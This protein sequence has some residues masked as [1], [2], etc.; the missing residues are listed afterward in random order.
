MGGCG[1][2]FPLIKSNFN[3]CQRHIQIP[4]SQS[5]NLRQMILLSFHA[6]LGVGT[7]Q[8]LI[9]KEPVNYFPP[10]SKSQKKKKKGFVFM[11][12]VS[13]LLSVAAGFYCACASLSG[14]WGSTAVHSRAT[15]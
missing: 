6:T 1:V 7:V 4:A 12:A 8:I 11:C 14:F 5:A 10:A 13:V 9:K 3:H 15:V 2:R